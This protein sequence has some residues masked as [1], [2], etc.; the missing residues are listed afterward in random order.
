MNRYLSETLGTFILVF[1]GTG[2]IIIHQE[3]GQP[4]HEG[5]A[6]TFGLVVMVLIY[7]LGKYSGAHFNPAVSIAF[8]VNK[9]FHAN[10]LLPY[11]ICQV[12][13]AILA[14]LV[15]KLLFP[16]NSNLGSTVPSGTLIQSFVLEFFL[17]FFLML[18]IL[19]TADESKYSGVI[20]PLAI[21]ATVGLEAMFAGP[22]CGASMNPA[23]SI[24]PALVS[25]N[26]STLWIYI[27]APVS[28]AIVSTFLITKKHQI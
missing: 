24:G 11:I 28:G 8:A 12:G 14:S 3:L 5:I 13:G 2:A 22:V 1:C 21:G 25:G 4:S 26:F 20:A 23:R 27:L 17:T 7:G 10:K 6:A 18:V 19:T 15:L 9:K 16:A